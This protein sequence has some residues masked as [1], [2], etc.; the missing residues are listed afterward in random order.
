[1]TVNDIS[2]S[3]VIGTVSK[4]ADA[5]KLGGVASAD[6]LDG[7][8]GKVK[9]AAA[10]DKLATGRDIVL[11]GDATGTATGFDGTA[12]AEITVTLKNVG[13]SGTYT[14]VTT[15]AQGRVTAGDTLAATDIPD[16]T[17][18][19]ITDA[20]NLAGLD[21][22][23]YANL[24]ADLQGRITEL[25]RVDH[26]HANKAV[27]DGITSAQV[28][29]WDETAGKI[30]GKADKATTLAGYGITDAYTKE[31]INGKLTGALHY[32]G[33]KATFQA[34]LNEVTAGDYVPE[35]GDVWNIEGAG[36]TDA[37]GTAIKDGDNVI[38]NGTGWDASSGTTDLSAYST[39]AQTQEKLDLKADKTTVEGINN[40]VGEAE[41]KIVKLET[42]S[43]EHTT[44]LGTLDT[45]VT[46]LKTTVGDETKGL[47]KGVADNAAA[48]AT[49]NGDVNTEG[50]VKKLIAASA[51]D[52][53]NTIDAITKD[54]GTIDTKVS[55]AVSTH[56]TATDAHAD[57]FAA[58]QNKIIQ[59]QVTF[60][61]SDFVENTDETIPAQY[62][63]TKAVTGLDTAKSYAPNVAP[64]LTSCAT[65]VAAQFYPSA[66]VNAGAL[67]LY[68]V[69]APT[70]AIVVNGTFT[71]IQ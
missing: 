60:E 29:A 28:T 34:L 58:K 12:N 21:E 65:V 38:F 44:K 24:N 63:A 8:T 25:E 4:A 14:K 32:K 33:T 62:M 39:T 70:A 5:E 9:S 19:K 47:V 40:R 64:T 18:A 37:N 46:N 66:S 7:T 22:V 11:S 67:T 69:N 54:G 49:L 20:G 53:N 10:A 59:A 30:D 1:M 56:N 68:C 26:D 48:I 3:K 57:L 52:I 41:T 51:T 43:S 27:I 45:D 31:Q 15:D 71:E 23:A 55:T 2:A 35:T 17:L 42:T 36:G 16:L 50:S 61:A 6:I 13:T